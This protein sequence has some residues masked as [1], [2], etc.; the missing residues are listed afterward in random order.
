VRILKTFI[1]F[2]G[3]SHERTT[4]PLT[5]K[6]GATSTETYVT[7]LDCGKE[8]AYDWTEMRIKAALPGEKPSG[9]F[10]VTR[11]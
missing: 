3:C 5:P 9:T 11:V 4:F 7:C 8:F 10:V 2:F 6:P 1:A